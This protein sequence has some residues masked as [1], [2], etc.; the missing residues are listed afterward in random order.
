MC[1]CVHVCVSYWYSYLLPLL[2]QVSRVRSQISAVDDEY[3]ALLS[4]SPTNVVGSSEQSAATDGGEPEVGRDTTTEKEEWLASLQR[5]QQQRQQ[6]QRKQIFKAGRRSVNRAHLD[7]LP[8]NELRAMGEKELFE[9]LRADS[10]RAQAA[11]RL[12]RRPRWREATKARVMDDG[13]SAT[14]ARRSDPVPTSTEGA[15]SPPASQLQKQLQNEIEYTKSLRRRPGAKQPGT[16]FVPRSYTGA[17]GAGLWAVEQYTLRPDQWW[18]PPDAVAE[19]LKVTAGSPAAKSEQSAAADGGEAKVGRDKTA[20]KEEW[21]TQFERLAGKFALVAQ[22]EREAAAAAVA[23]K[24][25]VEAQEAAEEAQRIVG[26]IKALRARAEEAG[27]DGDIDN[28]MALMDE[29]K[30]LELELAA[31]QR[32]RQRKQQEDR[33]SAAGTTAPEVKGTSGHVAD[34]EELLE[35]A[36]ELGILRDL[37]GT[38]ELGTVCRWR[39]ECAMADW[40][41]Q[42][43]DWE[44]WEHAGKLN[45]AITALMPLLNGTTA[46]RQCVPE[47][48]LPAMEKR[49]V[50]PTPPN[51]SPER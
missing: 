37:R 5:Q 24:A 48:L 9:K 42:Y 43:S 7:K 41:E 11:E 30:E 6:Q 26:N 8:S 33:D 14:P 4:Q 3:N 35:F 21:L 49:L 27:A 18:S 38:D 40:M 39:G 47:K 13:A 28:A 19:K 16:R 31:R 44:Q 23:A 50:V 46:T 10:E 29:A 32:E 20:E 15:Q 34:V 12:A 45:L 1:E 36:Q 22:R 17:S 51:A 25:A 2:C